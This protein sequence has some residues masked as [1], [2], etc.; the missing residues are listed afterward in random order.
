MFWQPP[1]LA[2]S[3]REYGGG[4]ELSQA[5]VP[6]GS[7]EAALHSVRADLWDTSSRGRQ[8]TAPHG[9]FPLMVLKSWGLRTSGQTSFYS[10]RYNCLAGSLEQSSLLEQISRAKPYGLVMISR[11]GHMG[12]P[13]DVHGPA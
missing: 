10:L 11:S 5:L 4:G 9:L 8:Q 6:P 1:E 2:P 3:P 12:A 7:M 13:T